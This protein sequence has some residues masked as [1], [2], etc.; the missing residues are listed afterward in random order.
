MKNL[1]TP[2]TS[3]HINDITFNNHYEF[4]T[5]TG[6]LY[7]LVQDN[8]VCYD[9]VIFDFDKTCGKTIIDSISFDTI[10]MLERFFVK[11]YKYYLNIKMQ[12]YAIDHTNKTFVL[13]SI[14]QSEVDRIE[15]N[16]NT[17]TIHI[18]NEHITSHT[19]RCTNVITF[20]DRFIS[21]N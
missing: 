20:K 19:F 1:T 16:D 14:D 10:D 8:D 7:F 4:L 21:I 11:T 15:Y 12:K 17:F 18:N 13:E 6:S 5:L 2:L 3:K 9:L